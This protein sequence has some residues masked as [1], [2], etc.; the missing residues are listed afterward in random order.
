MAH[1]MFCPFFPPGAWVN[2]GLGMVKEVDGQLVWTYTAQHL[3]YWIAAPLPGT[4]GMATA[5]QAMYSC[6]F[7]CFIQQER[8]CGMQLH[9]LDNFCLSPYSDFS[10]MFCKFV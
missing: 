2:R 3:G 9:H 10:C 1:A 4:R 7:D 8:R 5:G 6:Q